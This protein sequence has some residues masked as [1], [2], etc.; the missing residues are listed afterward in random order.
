MTL[1]FVHYLGETLP[2]PVRRDAIDM[3]IEADGLES[4]YAKLRDLHLRKCGRTC[5]HVPGPLAPEAP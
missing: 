3:Q 4:V 2:R 1:L 5:E